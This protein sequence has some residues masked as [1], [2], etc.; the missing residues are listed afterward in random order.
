MTD[1]KKQFIQAVRAQDVELSEDL[2]RRIPELNTVG[3]LNG[4]F[5]GLLAQHSHCTLDVRSQLIPTD[6]FN[7]WFNN[8]NSKVL[9]YIQEKRLPTCTDTASGAAYKCQSKAL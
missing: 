3:E 9:P 7:N 8:F 6:D 1:I 5:H 4:F 2:Y